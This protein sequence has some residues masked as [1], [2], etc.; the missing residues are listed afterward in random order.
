MRVLHSNLVST[1][2]GIPSAKQPAALN[3]PNDLFG[4][5]Q[6]DRCPRTEYVSPRDQAA[7]PGRRATACRRRFHRRDKASSV[8]A[9]S[10]HRRLRLPGGAHRRWP[11]AAIAALCLVGQLSVSAHLALVRHATCPEH[12]EA[13]HSG[14]TLAPVAAGESGAGPSDYPSVGALTGG[15][16][17][18]DHEHCVIATL[19]RERAVFQRQQL[20]VLGAAPSESQGSHHLPDAPPSPVAL[21]LIAPKGSPPA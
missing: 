21:F 19:R 16:S 13:I 18:H 4:E 14:K 12:G 11:S 7:T 20:G 3:G 1:I 15:A 6:I 17:R 10:S 8:M 9:S 2:A 5:L